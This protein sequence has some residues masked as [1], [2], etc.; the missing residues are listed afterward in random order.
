MTPATAHPIRELVEDMGLTSHP[1]LEDSWPEARQVLELKEVTAPDP[2]QRGRLRR[3]AADLLDLRPARQDELLRSFARYGVDLSGLRPTALDVTVAAQPD[4]PEV[5]VHFGQRQWPLRLALDR[6][7]AAPEPLRDALAQRAAQAGPAESVVV[8]VHLQALSEEVMEA[9]D[10]V[11]WERLMWS[12]TGPIA[13]HL[14]RVVDSPSTPEPPKTIERVSFFAHAETSTSEPEQAAVAA[15]WPG[16]LTHGSLQGD[17]AHIH[18]HGS[19]GFVQGLDPAK[20]RAWAVVVN[21]CQ[22]ARSG[23][24]VRRLVRLGRVAHAMGFIDNVKSSVTETVAR[25]WHSTVAGAQ[26][27]LPRSALRAGVAV[28]AALGA[29]PSAWLWRHYISQHALAP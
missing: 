7:L 1:M 23:G 3:L 4:S 24:H 18:A 10:A 6:P 2:H 21:A 26:A 22:G 11:N 19:A 27:D 12:P 28:R 20:V 25:V 29:Q 8:R 5:H 13:D 15:A 9:A 17:L 16:R 14:V